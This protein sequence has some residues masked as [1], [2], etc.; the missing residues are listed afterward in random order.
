MNQRS[1][2][3]VDFLT[4]PTDS[5]QSNPS[6]SLSYSEV[7]LQYAQGTLN[8]RNFKQFCQEGA[9]VLYS[10]M[11]VFCVHRFRFRFSGICFGNDLIFSHCITQKSS[12][13][14]IYWNDCCFTAH[15]II[16]LSQ[17]VCFLPIFW[18]PKNGI[19]VASTLDF[20]SIIWIS[21]V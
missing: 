13:K 15:S 17:P 8:D 11:P 18:K 3:S 21:G 6:Q 1:V 5:K 10:R 12:L 19:V 9:F 16:I 4:F 14:S 7:L 20:E 2:V